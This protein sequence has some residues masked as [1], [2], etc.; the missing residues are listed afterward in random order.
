MLSQMRKAKKGGNV[1]RGGGVGVGGSRRGREIL[2][3]HKYLVLL[4]VPEPA[5]F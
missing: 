1:E 3:K 5:L 2:L 4:L